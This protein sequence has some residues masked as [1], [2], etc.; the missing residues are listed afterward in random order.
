MGGLVVFSDVQVSLAKIFKSINLVYPNCCP[1]W[2][3]LSCF[4]HISETCLTLLKPQYQHSNSHE[5]WSL[6]FLEELICSK[7]LFKD[8]SIFIWVF[9]LLILITFYIDYV[10]TL[11]GENWCLSL[12]GTYRVNHA[13][14]VVILISISCPEAAILLVSTKDHL[15]LGY[16]RGR[17]NLYSHGSRVFQSLEMKVYTEWITTK[18][19][20]GL[21]TSDIGHRHLTLDMANR[22]I[23]HQTSDIGHRISDIGHRTSDIGH[24]TSGHRI[25]DIRHRTSDIE[26]QCLISAWKSDQ[27][28]LIFASLISPSRIILF[29]K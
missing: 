12:K 24:R 22:S 17:K 15:T 10:M 27:K 21:P 9:I 11:V 1:L 5:Y 26:H 3:C 7:N 29:E 13:F 23:G 14:S 28:L 16:P 25:S 8:Q 18:P 19:E 2:T 20:E 6:C 4:V